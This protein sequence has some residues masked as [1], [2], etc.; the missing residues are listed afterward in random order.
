MA[1]T[2]PGGRQARARRRGVGARQYEPACTAGIPN[3]PRPPLLSKM[4]V[5][6]VRPTHGSQ[7]GNY[8][9]H[10]GEH[11]QEQNNGAGGGMSPRGRRASEVGPVVSSPRIMRRASD[12]EA[13]YG[14]SYGALHGVPYGGGG[15]R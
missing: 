9:Q 3:A 11:W 10:Q 1:R 8:Q 7:G 2:R 15:M 4:Q 13:V 5:V 12:A 14:V 6:E